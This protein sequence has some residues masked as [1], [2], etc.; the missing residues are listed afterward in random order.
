MDDEKED[1]VLIEAFMKR[2]YEV[3]RV[4]ENKIRSIISRRLGAFEEAVN[5]L[6]HITSNCISDIER[7]L[8]EQLHSDSTQH[9]NSSEKRRKL[10]LYAKDKDYVERYVLEAVKSFCRKKQHYWTHGRAKANARK[11]E[12]HKEIKMGRA[13]RVYW[14]EDGQDL[15]DWLSQISASDTNIRHLSDSSL[16]A[17]MDLFIRKR[18]SD[19]KIMC[20]LSRLFGMT[21]VE[22]AKQDQDSN[23][24]PDKYRKQFKRMVAQLERNKEELRDIL[25]D[26]IE[27]DTY[28]QPN[29]LNEKFFV[30]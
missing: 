13:A 15:N 22:I 28:E 21:F 7:I 26:N 10:A 16:E 20:F 27:K 30:D 2:F 9:F 23:A 25:L 12:K 11:G 1:C 6:D 17:L 4:K 19:D 3:T 5:N 24:T 14:K 8:V 18:F 29:S